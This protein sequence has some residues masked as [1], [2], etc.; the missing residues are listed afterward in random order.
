MPELRT[1]KAKMY[2]DVVFGL[3]GEAAPSLDD[4]ANDGLLKENKMVSTWAGAGYV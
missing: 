3:S 1:A 2:F 4:D